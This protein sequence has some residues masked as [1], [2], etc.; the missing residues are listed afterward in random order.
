MSGQDCDKVMFS[1]RRYYVYLYFKH[2]YKVT[3]LVA[4][5]KSDFQTVTYT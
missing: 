3:F 2:G 1:K 4:Q 5:T